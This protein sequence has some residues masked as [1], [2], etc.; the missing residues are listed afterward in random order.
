MY[1]LFHSPLVVTTLNVPLARISFKTQLE[2]ANKIMEFYQQV[3]L[4]GEEELFMFLA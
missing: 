2:I 4:V 1:N 3:K